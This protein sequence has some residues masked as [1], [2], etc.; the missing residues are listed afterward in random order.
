METV[1]S[2]VRLGS[3]IVTSASLTV[4]GLGAVVT[5]PQLGN[6]SLAT[7]TSQVALAADAVV[8]NFEALAGVAV[9]DL[10]AVA[11]EF[12]VPGLAEAIAVPGLADEFAVPGLA[13]AVA[14]PTIAVPAIADA[15][16]ALGAYQAEIP[17]SANAFDFVG[18][19]HAQVAAALGLINHFIMLPVTV[20]NDF[21][22][23]FNSLVN[24]NFGL[25]FSQAVSIPF[26][27]FNYVNGLPWEVLNTA[28][29]MLFVLPGQYLFNFG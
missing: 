19:F 17:G 20:V 4:G 10:S 26:D 1:K 16:D 18:L 24:L 7:L 12:A 6:H 28:F 11:D 14:V 8:D 13:E 3:A 22:N 5:A 15:I 23:V 2:A 29:Q 9:P 21:G 25:A 27:L